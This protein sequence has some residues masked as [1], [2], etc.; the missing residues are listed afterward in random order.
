[1]GNGHKK[2][3]IKKPPQFKACSLG[4]QMTIRQIKILSISFF[5]ISYSLSDCFLLLRLYDLIQRVGST[6]DGLAQH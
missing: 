4:S 1:M 3:K 2:K 5:L 6:V